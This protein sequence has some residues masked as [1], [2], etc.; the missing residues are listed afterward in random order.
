MFVRVKK[1]SGNDY[2]Y[3]VE[4]EWTKYGARQR[5]T[6]Y[7]GKVIRPEKAEEYPYPELQNHKQAVQALVQRELQ[8]HGFEKNDKL[9]SKED[10]TINLENGEVKKKG[11]NVALGMNEGFL[12][13]ET[14]QQAINFKLGETHDESAKALAAACLE[15]G[16]KLSDAA[17]VRLFELQEETKIEH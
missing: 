1:I 8:N 13:K 10:I 16:I 5:V 11:K 2:A 4:N 3:L 14:Y 6:A 12:T 15:A 7:L 17:F 9:W